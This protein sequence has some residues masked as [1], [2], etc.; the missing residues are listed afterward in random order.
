MAKILIIEDN[1]EVRENISEILELS[2]F[3]TSMA[4]N[5]KVGVELAL[6]EKPDLILCDVMMPELDGFGV[7]RILSG[8]RLTA[9]I[10]FIFLTAKSEQSDFRKGMGLGADD[11]ITKPFDDVEL[12]DA[13]EMRLKKSQKIKEA[14]SRS[15]DGLS[16][17]YDAAKA[18]QDLLKLSKNREERN[19]SRKSRI[20][21]EGQRANWLYFISKG[22]VKCF[23]TNEYGKE[24]ITHIYSEGEFFGYLPLIKNTTYEES[25]SV[26]E[27]ACI[28][29]I[30]K[31][32]FN[33]LLFSNR[34]FGIQFIKMLANQVT[35]TEEN[36]INLAYNSVRQKV[37]N[38]L[39]I[40][41]HKY[42]KDGQARFSILRED[43]AA[44]AAT[45]KETVI[46]TISDFKDEGV[47]TIEENDIVIRSLQKLENL[48][49]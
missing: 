44:L 49:Y 14:F 22:K 36:L 8:N 39:T 48:R 19:L 27:D 47:V 32:D 23:K 16:H 3:D 43:L 2:G 9:D 35:E 18:H 29:L 12:M 10:P 4:E 13:I 33:L 46:R 30:P 38:A 7:L 15:S 34:E 21:E 11:Y 1:L 6:E 28:I 20:F 26:I 24:L 41:Y 37:A 42:E 17:F 45:A 5:G 40:L 31:S 25:A